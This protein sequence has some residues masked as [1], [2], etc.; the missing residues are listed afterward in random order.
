MV[1]NGGKQPARGRVSYSHIH[2]S[3]QDSEGSQVFTSTSS[4]LSSPSRSMDSYFPPAVQLGATTSAAGPASARGLHLHPS[5]NEGTSASMLEARHNGGPSSTETRS[6]STPTEE[7][8]LDLYSLAG[9]PVLDQSIPPDELPD[10]LI[11]HDAHDL[12]YPVRYVRVTPLAKGPRLYAVPVRDPTE[13]QRPRRVAQLHLANDNHIGHGHGH[14]HGHSTVFRAPLTLPVAAGS[15]VATRVRVVAKTPAPVC[16]SH[17]QLHQEASMYH[18]FPLE[19]SEASTRHWVDPSLEV[20]GPQH[21]QRRGSEGSPEVPP[22]RRMS[23]WRDSLPRFRR[24]PKKPA[25]KQPT[26]AAGAAV[27]KPQPQPHPGEVPLRPLKALDVP[28]VVP[29]FFGYYLLLKPDGRLFFELSEGH[30]ECGEDGTC[31]VAWPP[32]ILLI[33]DCGVPIQPSLFSDAHRYVILSL[34]LSTHMPDLAVCADGTAT[35]SS[36]AYTALGSSRDSSPSRHGRRRCSSSPGRSLCRAMRARTRRRASALWTS[37]GRSADRRASRST[38]RSGATT[39]W[40]AR[41]TRCNWT[42]EPNNAL[43]SLVLGSRRI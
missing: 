28:P 36:T 1:R 33:E 35:A 43:S 31:G 18:A 6:I 22:K 38:G 29:K 17:R 24:K 34:S 37:G 7:L 9:L 8:D 41:L 2:T 21:Q 19:L 15:E 4:D 14:G 10:D 12:P 25:E 23:G 5:R 16:G 3:S 20:G 13:I 32:A 26:R 42:I 27:T 30:G 11:I 40:M 39:T